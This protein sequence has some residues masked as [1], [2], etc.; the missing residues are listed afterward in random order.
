MRKGYSTDY[1]TYREI[2]GELMRPITG[3]GLDTDTLKRLYE[4]KLVYLE[5]LR[6][7]CF[8]QLNSKLEGPF[9]GDDYALIVQALGETRKQVRD[10]ML[11]AIQTHLGRKAV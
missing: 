1:A 7:K 4:S 5:H 2:M 6:V 3:E 8:F 9:T 10:L 11:I